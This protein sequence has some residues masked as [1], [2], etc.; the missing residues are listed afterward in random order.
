MEYFELLN[1]SREPFSN[2]PDP[3]LFYPT[4]GYLQALQKLEIAVRLR[5][6]L[7]LVLGDV[8]TGKTTMSR[9][10][11]RSFEPQQDGFS[12]HLLL[13]PGFPSDEEMLAHLIRL[14]G[15]EPPERGARPQLM[16]ALQHILLREAVEKGKVVVLFID[17]G[18]KLTPSGLETLRELLNFESNQ[19]KLL[20]VVVFAQLELWERL[21][22][23][24]NLLDRVNLMVRLEPLNLHETRALVHHRLTQSGMPAQKQLFT[25]GAVRLVH[26][27]SG[28]H[29]RKI[30]N[31]CHHSILRAILIQ[32]DQVDAACVKAAHREIRG[33]IEARVRDRGRNKRPF[34][35]AGLGCLL[36]AGAL[37]LLWGQVGIAPMVDSTR[38]HRPE[39]WAAAPA[40]G[41]REAPESS[42]ELQD[43]SG[44]A[45]SSVLDMRS[46]LVR[47][48]GG[49]GWVLS[50][51]PQQWLAD[52]AES[53]ALDSGVRVVVRKGDTLS[54]LVE[55]NLGMV[56]DTESQ[57]MKRFIRANPGVSNPDR[58]RPGDSLLLPLQKE[59]TTEVEAEP[60]A[61]FP[62]GEKAELWARQELERAGEGTL[63]LVR[64]QRDG[65]AGFLVFRVL[66]GKGTGEE[67]PPRARVMPGDILQVLTIH[68]SP[69]RGEP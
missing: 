16:D 27:L 45:Q 9:V 28:G 39:L 55:R 64:E 14:L 46:P 18:Q 50:I 48:K 63:L 68:S 22:R 51:S 30:I 62:L 37:Y 54:S 17:E 67:A 69:G 6:G 44:Q 10:L 11:L 33:I 38:E 43:S 56:L 59:P 49:V 36:A 31:L 29:P 26:Q 23:M 57:W 35:A 4:P 42:Q 53:Q 15:G 47:E 1:L 25:K 13:D 5:R 65:Q 20:Q 61:W 60:V 3:E 58:L 66:S 32:A 21:E 52:L 24:P 7:N 19:W 12:V 8:G 2:S 40:A 41:V 34:L